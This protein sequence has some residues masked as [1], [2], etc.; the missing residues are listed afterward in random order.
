MDENK[1]TKYPEFENLEQI[2]EFYTKNR[3]LITT[4]EEKYSIVIWLENYLNQDSNNEIEIKLKVF[5]ILSDILPSLTKD[6]Y[7]FSIM[8]EE[9]LYMYPRIF[10]LGYRMDKA[11][12]YRDFG[13]NYEYIIS[14]RKALKEFG[15]LNEV[16]EILMEDIERDIEANE[17]RM[18]E[19]QFLAN[20]IKKRINEL[21]SEGDSKAAMS[22]LHQLETTTPYDSELIEY[23]SRII[24][25][26]K[27]I[28]KN[29]IKF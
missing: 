8:K 12:E 27:N 3:R 25:N 18:K 4:V 16:V 28:S 5:K 26:K 22:A 29:T 14:I 13:N 9:N 1:K 7:N 11:I 17:K 10:R 23:K 24:E 2:C 20:G 6:I 19:F 15:S 21:I